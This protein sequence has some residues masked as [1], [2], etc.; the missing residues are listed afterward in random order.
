MLHRQRNRV[1]SEIVV[2]TANPGQEGLT[3]YDALLSNF[4][5]ETKRV[6]CPKC[7]NYS[8]KKSRHGYI[9]CDFCFQ[10]FCSFC[11]SDKC[12]HV[13]TKYERQIE[14][15]G[16]RSVCFYFTTALLLFPLVPF[17]AFCI[18]PF[19]VIKY[20]L[21]SDLNLTERRDAEIFASF[22]CPTVGNI[23]FDF[24]V[25]GCTHWA[26]CIPCCCL[27]GRREV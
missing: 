2:G 10:S 11:H 1:N 17:I 27:K 4:C 20:L 5:F 6:R 24:E 26:C 7:C 18:P 8:R 13:H 3:T 15:L 22:V 19:F 21:T 23:I 16:N 25:R 14:I 12:L 9:T